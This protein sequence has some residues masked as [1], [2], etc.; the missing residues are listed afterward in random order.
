MAVSKCVLLIG[1]RGCSQIHWFLS[2]AAAEHLSTQSSSQSHGAQSPVGEKGLFTCLQWLY[3]SYFHYIIIIEQPETMAL[4]NGD[5][6]T[7]VGAT[8]TVNHDCYQVIHVV[9]ILSII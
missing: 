3:I 2:S 9:C 5:V 7:S 1:R 6:M 8:A 4:D